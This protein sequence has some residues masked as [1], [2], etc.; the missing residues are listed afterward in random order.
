M[1]DKGYAW[2]PSKCERECDQACNETVEEVKIAKINLAKNE[3]S[4]KCSS[5]TVYIVLLLI[6][7]TINV[8]G[9]VTYYVYSHWYLKKDDSHVK[10]N[11]YKETTI[12]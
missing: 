4:C 12:Y 9:I 2:N 3:N 11:T 1:C 10:F 8:S 6:F 7:F 5:C